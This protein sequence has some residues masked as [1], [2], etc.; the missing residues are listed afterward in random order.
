MSAHSFYYR[1]REWDV[2]RADYIVTLAGFSNIEGTPYKAYSFFIL[3]VFLRT[4]RK[5]SGAIQLGFL[6]Y[7]EL[8]LEN[9]TIVP[10]FRVLHA[11]L[12]W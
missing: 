3:F 10:L 11:A 4:T 7:H 1:V 2:F 8:V 5:L 9:S 6:T 12:G